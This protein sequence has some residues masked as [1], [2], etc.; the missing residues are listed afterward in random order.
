MTILKSTSEKKAVKISN[1]NGTFNAV[2]VQYVNT[3]IDT[4]E[5]VLEH[6]AYASEKAATKWAN[7][8]LN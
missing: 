1:N 2:Y 8:I 3:G 4:R 6:R 7:K 5:Q